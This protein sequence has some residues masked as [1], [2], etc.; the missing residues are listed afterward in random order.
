M[1]QEH[2]SN[3]E[4]IQSS[5]NLVRRNLER[6]LVGDMP[7]LSGKDFPYPA[8]AKLLRDLITPKRFAD[9]GRNPPFSAIETVTRSK[10]AELTRP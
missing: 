5:G 8:F 10:R 2:C 9:R 1:Q 6:K 3:L 4:T 7:V